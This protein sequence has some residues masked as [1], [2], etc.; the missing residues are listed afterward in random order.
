MEISFDR[1]LHFSQVAPLTCNFTQKGFHGRYFSVV[2]QS[3]PLQIYYRTPVA[4]APIPL[5]FNF[6]YEIIMKKQAS[7]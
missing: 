5:I 4:R 2:L 3:F 1:D 6:S 7:S